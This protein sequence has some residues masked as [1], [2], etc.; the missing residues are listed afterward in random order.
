[1]PVVVVVEVVRLEHFKCFIA[2]FAAHER[3]HFE[4][5]K[6]GLLLL[7]PA[8]QREKPLRLD[9]SDFKQAIAQCLARGLIIVLILQLRLAVNGERQEHEAQKTAGGVKHRAETTDADCSGNR[10]G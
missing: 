8:G 1:M 9:G 7:T 3:L 2:L 5:G 4:C 6:R 10:Y